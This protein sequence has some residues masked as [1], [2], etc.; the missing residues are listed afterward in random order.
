MQLT[1]E[2]KKGEKYFI[3]RCPELGVTTQ[4]RTVKEAKEKLKEAVELHLEAM[5]DYMIEHG[6]VCIERGKI[7]EA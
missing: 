3:A 2:I 4:G 5:I 6:R 7:I 1:A